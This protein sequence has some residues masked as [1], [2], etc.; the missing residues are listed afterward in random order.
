MTLGI[1][2]VHASQQESTTTVE[3]KRPAKKEDDLNC[4]YLLTN[5]QTIA[6]TA[7][8]GGLAL[9]LSSFSAV[10]LAGLLSKE[11]SVTV[12]L[13]WPPANIK[14]QVDVG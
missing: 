14:K 4:E 13:G 3:A 9:S 8:L 12:T 1:A 11:D 5:W 7:V 10:V 2:P 6:I